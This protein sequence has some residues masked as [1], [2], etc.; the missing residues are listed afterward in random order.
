[1]AEKVAMGTQRQPLAVQAVQ[2][3]VAA[4][5]L[6]LIL[7]AEQLPLDKEKQAEQVRLM[8]LTLQRQAVVVTAQL[9]QTAR[10]HH[11]IQQVQVEQEQIPLQVLVQLALG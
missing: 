5:M 4:A 2:V 9:V 3:A 11:L 8:V 10:Q 7:L 1:V 6:Q